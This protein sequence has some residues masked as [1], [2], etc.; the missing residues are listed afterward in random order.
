MPTMIDDTDKYLDFFVQLFE[1]ELLKEHRELFFWKNA[2][3]YL[4]LKT[5]FER[6]HGD[7]IPAVV[8][9]YVQALRRNIDGLNS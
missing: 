9:N 5:Y 6:M 3:D 2:L 4:H 1:R 7:S 8:L